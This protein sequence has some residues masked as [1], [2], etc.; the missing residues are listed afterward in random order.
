MRTTRLPHPGRVV[1]IVVLTVIGGVGLVLSEATVALDS[2]FDT[3]TPASDPSLPDPFARRS[4]P[5]ISIAFVVF[6]VAVAGGA[7]WLGRRRHME[8][9]EEIH[10]RPEGPRVVMADE[11]RGRRRPPGFYEDLRQRETMLENLGERGPDRPRPKVIELPVADHRSA[12]GD[13]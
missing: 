11:P 7:L 6:L 5:L 3:S 4:T 8:P 13:G 12:E 10:P 2:A 9:E 1:L